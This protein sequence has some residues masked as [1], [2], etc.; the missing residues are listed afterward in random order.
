MLFGNTLHNLDNKNRLVIPRKFV[1]K[2]GNK[3]YILKGYEGCLSLF[4]EDA[5][6]TY[7]NNLS[8]YD[9]EKKNS[10]DVIRVALS[11][12]YELEIDSKNRIQ[13]P[14]DL[15]SKYQ[16][17]NSLMVVG[18]NDHLELWNKDKWNEYIS[19]AEESYEQNSER[20]LGDKND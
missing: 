16:I 7:I 5:F 18:V 4:S 2:L 17:S 12:V 1:N 20:L 14:C 15:I 10:R 8:K 9:F 6:K 11:S 19:V 3:V 13:L